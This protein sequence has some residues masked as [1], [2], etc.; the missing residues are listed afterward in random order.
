[1]NKPAIKRQQDQPRHPPPHEAIQVIKI[2]KTLAEGSKN[3]MAIYRELKSDAGFRNHHSFYRQ[4]HFCLRHH[5]VELRKVKKKWGIPTKI[6]HLT[7]EGE[8]LLRLFKETTK[9]L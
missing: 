9:L 4:F 3:T 7:E 1:L 2:L 6:Y 8:T 5:L